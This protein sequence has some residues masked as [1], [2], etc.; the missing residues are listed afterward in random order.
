MTDAEIPRQLDAFTL[1]REAVDMRS[2]SRLGGFYYLFAWLLVWG[3][4]A[5]PMANWPAGLGLGLLFGLTLALR[6]LHDLPTSHDPDLL[7]HW[8][9]RRWQLIHFT[10]LAWG[11]VQ[12]W[13]LLD[14]A[15]R[16]TRLI[17]TL[18]TIAF[19]TA[20]VSTFAMNRRCCALAILLLYLPGLISLSRDDGN[21]GELVTLTFYFSYLLL[22]LNRSHTDY[23]GN[24]ALELQLIEQRDRLDTLSRTDSL[25]QLGNRYQF[26]NLFPSM[27]A[28]A[29]RQHGSL[30]LVLLDIDYFKHVNDNFGHTAGDLCLQ[31]FAER[32]RQVFRR[33]SD[34]LL[35]LGGEEFGVLMPDTSLEQ[36]QSLAESFRQNLIHRGFEVQGRTLPLTASLGVGCFEP[37]QDSAESFFKRVDDALYKAKATGRDRMVLASYASAQ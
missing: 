35:R 30:A 36:A 6:W 17:A 29:Q 13:V 8:M 20:M 5:A 34:A 4:S 16:D 37:G 2:R 14:E 1:W 28:A 32:M 12:A 18:S 10:S 3:F 21:L 33:D 25:T 23:H 7:R 15:Y 11:L 19:S 9:K 31:H 26:N 27:V 22:A 24:L